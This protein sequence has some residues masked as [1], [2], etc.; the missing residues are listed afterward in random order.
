MPFNQQ[1]PLNLKTKDGSPIKE[2]NN[3]KY[4]GGWMESSEKDFSIQKAMAWSACH[5]MRKIWSSNLSRKIKVRLFL[6]TV[7]SVLLYGADTW[8]ITKNFEKKLNG[9]YTRMLRM[10]LNISWKRHLTNEQ[11][12]QD[13]PRVS[14]KVTQRRLRLAGHC[15]RHPEEIASDL[16]LWQPLE[17]RASRGRKTKTYVDT[18]LEDTEIDNVGELKTQMLDRSVWMNHVEAVVRPGGRR[19]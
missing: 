9:V 8:T 11:L 18:L 7:E 6:A 17:G 16:I 12:Y 14:E 15:I 4:L 5:K 1:L 3:F 10:C 19:R 13:L 2:V